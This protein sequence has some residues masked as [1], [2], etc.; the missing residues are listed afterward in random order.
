M[1]KL[2]ILFF[3]FFSGCSYAW[4][5]PGHRIVAEIAYQQLAPTAKQRIDQLEPNFVTASTWMDKIR[6]EDDVTA[7]NRWHYIGWGFSP[8]SLPLPKNHEDNVVWAIQ[9]SQQ[10]LQSPRAKKREKA[11]FLRALIHLTADVHQPLHAASRVT[12]QNPEGDRGGNLFKIQGGNLHG[13]WDSALG[14]RQSA[15]DLEANYP[16]SRYS[17]QVAQLDPMIWAKESYAIAT[18]FVYNTRE[19]AALSPDYIQKGQQIASERLVLAGYRLGALLNKIFT[20]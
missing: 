5:A 6:Q 13:A 20:D 11:L 2:L 16:M 17:A 4:N 10:V 3:L 14:L 7:F 15:R 1:R 19:G 9:Q 18:N 8:E 12:P